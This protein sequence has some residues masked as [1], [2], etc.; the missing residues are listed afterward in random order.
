MLSIVNANFVFNYFDFKWGRKKK[1]IQ[2]IFESISL[3]LLNQ[4]VDNRISFQ[5]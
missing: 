3:V 2:N 5:K 1:E 4:Y